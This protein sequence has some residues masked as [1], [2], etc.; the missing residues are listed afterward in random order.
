MKLFNGNKL[1]NRLLAVFLILIINLFYLPVQAASLTNLSDT[2]TRLKVSTASDHTIKFTTPT[3]VESSTDTITITMP[4]GFTIGSVDYTDIDLSHGAST[5]YETDETLAAAAGS[6]VWGAVFSSQIL[7][8]TAPTN[9]AAGEITANDKVVVE[10][11]LNASGGNAQITNN[12]SAAT[13]IIAVGGTFGDTGNIAVVIVTDEQIPVTATVNP[14]ITFTVANTA[15]ALGDLSPSG[16]STSNLNNIS[17]GTNATGGYSITVQDVG[18]TGTGN[19]GL[20]SSGVSNLIA[21]TTTTLVA[22]AEG[23]GGQCAVTAGSGSCDF[24]LTSAGEAVTGFSD[25]SWS[26]FAHYSSKPSS[27]DTYQIRVKAAISTSTTAGYYQDTLTLVATG[28]F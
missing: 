24:S 19:S 27:T 2:M 23:Y 25:S 4:T 7:T 6:G 20:Y 14:S 28:N 10:I 11:G 8:L 1:A 16:I 13:Y 26:A 15:F 5:G 21:S 12:S 17:V 3:G 22:G 18:G 9:A